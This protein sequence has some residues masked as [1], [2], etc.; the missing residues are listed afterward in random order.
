MPIRKFDF[1]LGSLALIHS[2][3]QTGGLPEDRFFLLAGIIGASLLMLLIG[4]VIML[5]GRS[6][7]KPHEAAEGK[8]APA[9]FK[10]LAGTAGKTLTRSDTP[11]V[12]AAQDAIIVIRDPTS[13]NWLVEVNGMRYASLKDIHDDR[14]ADKVLDALKGMQLFAG[15]I[16]I[17]NAAPNNDSVG[18]RLPSTEISAPPPAP[19]AAVI[20][21]IQT[22]RS[23]AQPKH[24]A[25]PGSLLEQV[26]K[27]LQRNLMKY[28]EMES[29]GIHIGATPQG[30][31]QIEVGDS[32]FNAPDDVPDFT[33]REL[34]KTSIM[35]W[36]RTA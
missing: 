10:N 24:P 30:G 9:W 3:P 1:M 7:S 25:A 11:E 4:V 18:S 34:I 28:P 15:S 12:A 32:Y 2:A 13:A 29:R 36:E 20:L 27:I 31:L 35:E 23:P 5:R 33:I 6:K 16:P 21:P 19:P 8:P 22:G 14:A 17:M 26:E